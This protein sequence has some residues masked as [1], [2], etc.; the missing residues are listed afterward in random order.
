MDV[1]RRRGR[2]RGRGRGRNHRHA[3]RH[4]TS[5]PK[6]PCSPPQL[7]CPPFLFSNDDSSLSSVWAILTALLGREPIERVV[8]LTSPADI[9]RERKE[10]RGTLDLSALLVDI[11]D[12]NLDR[13]VVFGLDDAASSGTLSGDVKVDEVS[14]EER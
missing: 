8:A 7:H 5:A 14:L 10:G 1:W 11:C 13:G 9:A 6:R 4:K 3:Q 2:A 12:G